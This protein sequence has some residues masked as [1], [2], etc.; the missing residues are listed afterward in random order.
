MKSLK[1]DSNGELV[2]TES[3]EPTLMAAG[4]G[5]ETKSPIVS[6]TNKPKSIPIKKSAK[7]SDLSASLLTAE[8]LLA[9]MQKAGGKDLHT[10][11]FAQMIYPRV[12]KSEDAYRHDLW[13]LAHG[14]VRTLMRSLA[15][16]GKVSI[17]RDAST[18]RILYVYNLL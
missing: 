3:A 16:Q 9:E 5:I 2:L 12:K 14:H 8:V 1:R 4:A 10:S 11:Q 13:D 18:K 6:E 15:K 17:T 7:L